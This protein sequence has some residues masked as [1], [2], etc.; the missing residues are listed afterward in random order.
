MRHRVDVTAG[1]AHLAPLIGFGFA[2]TENFFYFIGAF[3]EGG[4]V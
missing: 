3:D 4:F 2:M 1:R